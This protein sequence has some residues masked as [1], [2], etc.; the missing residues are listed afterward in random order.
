MN[1]LTALR[2]SNYSE[3]NYSNLDIEQTKVS[4]FPKL[5]NY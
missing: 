5:S 4:D 1:N 3:S 2:E